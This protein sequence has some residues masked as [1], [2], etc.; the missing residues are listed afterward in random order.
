MKK[1][2]CLVALLAFV[3]VAT[4]EVE[5]FFTSSTQP[6]GLKAGVAGTADPFV[7]SLFGGVDYYYGYQLFTTNASG[8]S[9]QTW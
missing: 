4:A 2:V 9:P 5:I 8:S 1:A 3:A 6:W 7:P